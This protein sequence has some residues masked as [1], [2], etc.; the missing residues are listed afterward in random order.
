MRG[1][2]FT[3]LTQK[4]HT[5]TQ[6]R[7]QDKIARQK[8]KRLV[9]SFRQSERLPWTRDRSLPGVWPPENWGKERVSARILRIAAAAGGNKGAQRRTGRSCLLSETEEERRGNKDSAEMVE[10]AE[11][12]AAAAD[13]G[14]LKGAAE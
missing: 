5:Y 11:A 4:S 13:A 12:V 7:K 10:A 8:K 14:G 1:F 2:L 3:L 6:G 9:T